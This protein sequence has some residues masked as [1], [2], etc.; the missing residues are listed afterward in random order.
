M[1]EKLTDLFLKDL[2]KLRDKEIPETVK[3]QVKRCLL[4][5]LGST[6][7]G[8]AMLGEKSK[9]LLDN[10]DSSNSGV[11]VIGFN[12]KA[13]IYNAALINGVNSHAAEMDDGVRFGMI[14]PGAPIFSALLPVA[15]QED[16]NYRD[17]IY[18][19]VTAYEAAVRVARAVQPNHYNMGYHPTGTCGAIGAAMGVAAMLGFSSDM[20]KDSL[21]AVTVASAGMLKVIEDGSELKP[22]NVGRAASS[23]VLAAYTASS[24]FNGLDDV[25]S[26]DIGFF[27]MMSKNADQSCLRK[28]SLDSYEIESAYF[29][30]YASCRHT[31]PSVE[32]VLKIKNVNELNVNE[33]KNISIKTY[34]G[35]IGKHDHVDIR[36]VSSAK[37]SLPFSV[38]LSL[39]TGKAG[40]AEFC[41]ENV[42]DET[43]LN[44]TRKV[45]VIPDEELSAL[46]PQKRAAIIEINTNDGAAY[47]ERVDFPKGE[48]ENPLSDNEIIEKFKTLS[49]FGKKTDNESEALVRVV[50]N[51]EENLDKLF[52]LI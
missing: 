13:G 41:V 34:K 43:I 51:L 12:R 44:L 47:S 29:K 36:S 20:M 16:V 27:S 52:Q 3:L 38:A 23:G 48:P 31:H 7:S 24:G 19:V 1:V 28:D 5:Y 11:S 42:S 35:I 22:F 4:D 6:L 30:P 10:L 15:E 2:C 39:I 46:V 8:K 14:H 26:G 21:S 9:K 45:T 37:M 50:W 17:F 40:I 18:G 33:I 25:F 32:G 49:A